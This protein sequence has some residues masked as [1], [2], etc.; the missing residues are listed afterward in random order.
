MFFQTALA[1]GPGS[2]KLS[3]GLGQ[4]LLALLHHPSTP[5]EIT[6]PAV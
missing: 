5:R 6:A 3:L 4:L 2:K 1:H